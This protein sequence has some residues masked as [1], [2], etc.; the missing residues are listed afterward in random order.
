MHCSWRSSR[1]SHRLG[2]A[3]K[4]RL[5]LYAVLVAVGASHD[6]SP[7]SYNY[8]ML[9]IHEFHIYI[10]IHQFSTYYFAQV[11]WNLD[12]IATFMTGYYEDGNLVLKP[13]KTFGCRPRTRHF[14][15]KTSNAHSCSSDSALQTSSEETRKALKQSPS[16]L[17]FLHPRANAPKL[18]Q[19][20][21]K[22]GKHSHKMAQHGPNITPKRSNM[23]PT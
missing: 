16:A 12:V 23:A 7:D 14:A 2:A 8:I 11:F 1:G 5:Q 6:K 18:G 20:T 15:Y 10:Y 9:K 13:T 21:T 19:H 17:F 4:L 22:I 3:A